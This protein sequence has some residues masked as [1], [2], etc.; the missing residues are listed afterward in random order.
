MA[1]VL[2]TKPSIEKF[3]NSQN[4]SRSLCYIQPS[5]NHPLP[6]RPFHHEAAFHYFKTST[7]S[8]FFPLWG[9]P[10]PESPHY[11][12][13]TLATD[14][15]RSPLILMQRFPPP[16]FIT[17]NTFISAG[18]YEQWQIFWHEIPST[19]SNNHSQ[20]NIFSTWRQFTSTNRIH[21]RYTWS[22]FFK[23]KGSL[24]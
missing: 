9:L 19:S 22:F 1:C 20:Y 16:M 3:V 6:R 23:E 24:P 4:S 2:A 13:E 17:C 5:R 21:V 18:S 7:S 14:C 10:R 12:P 8:R 11:K 15:L